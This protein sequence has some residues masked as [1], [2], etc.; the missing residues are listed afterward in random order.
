MPAGS[1]TVHSVTFT[2]DVA[3]K[4]LVT[5]TFEAQGQSGS[6]WGAGFNARAFALQGGTTTLGDPAGIS[7]TR[8]TGTVRGVFDVTAGTSVECGLYGQI[9]GAVGVTFWNIKVTAEHI[10]R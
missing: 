8:S 1:G 9:S 4:V 5:C 6:N 10:K 2:P 3:G 7:T